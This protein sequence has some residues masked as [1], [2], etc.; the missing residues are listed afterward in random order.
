MP[1]R[2]T[3]PNSPTVHDEVRVALAWLER[4]GSRRVRDGMARHAIPSD[5]AFGV[6]MSDIRILAKRLGRNRELATAL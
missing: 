1:A 4:R 2:K 5:H 3:T 6:S